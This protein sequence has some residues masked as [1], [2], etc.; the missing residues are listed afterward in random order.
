MACGHGIHTVHVN[1]DVCHTHVTPKEMRCTRFLL[2]GSIPGIVGPPRLGDVLCHAA[3]LQCPTAQCENAKSPHRILNRSAVMF[4]ECTS[5]RVG[6][7]P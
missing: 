4:L 5:P 6:P 3:L 2:T 1:V 7:P